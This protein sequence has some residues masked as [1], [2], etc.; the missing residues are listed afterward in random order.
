M[1]S[2]SCARRVT[3]TPWQHVLMTSRPSTR[4]VIVIV[5]A[6]TP[7]L[8]IGKKGPWGDCDRFPDLVF[9]SA[10]GAAAAAAAAVREKIDNSDADEEEG[11][12]P[13]C[14]PSKTIPSHVRCR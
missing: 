5:G 7:C 3:S 13:S 10:H 6:G 12:R 14:L 11:R 4:F 2:D 9:L 8:V 1:R